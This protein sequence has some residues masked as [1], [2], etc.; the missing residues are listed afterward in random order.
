MANIFGIQTLDHIHIIEV[1]EN[2]GLNAGTPAPFGSLALDRN[3]SGVWKKGGPA[4]TDWSQILDTAGTPIPATPNSPAV[5]APLVG[6]VSIDGLIDGPFAGTVDVEVAAITGTVSIGLVDL[7]GTVTVGS[8][9]LTGTVN[10]GVDD[11]FI[12]S[13]TIDITPGTQIVNGTGTAFLSDFVVGDYLVVNGEEHEISSVNSNILMGLSTP[14][15]AGAVADA[16]YSRNFDT[17]AVVGTGT[18]F[19]TELAPGDVVEVNGEFRT[20]NSVT[21]ATNFDV[22]VDFSVHVD[23][24]TMTR[25]ES[26]T[27][28]VGTGTLFTTELSPGQTIRINEEDH[29]ISSIANDTALTLTA[30]HVNTAKNQPAQL[31]EDSTTVR[32]DGTLFNTELIVGQFLEVNGQII[33][34]ASITSDTILD[35][36]SPYSGTGAGITATKHD[37]RVIGTGTAFTGAD[38]GRAIKIAGAYYVIDSHTDGLNVTISTPT[39]VDIDTETYSLHGFIVTGIGTQFITDGLTAGDTVEIE[40]ELHEIAS[41]DGELQI[42]LVTPHDAGAAGSPISYFGAGGT[43]EGV[44]WVKTGNPTQAMFTDS[45]GEDWVLN[46]DA[47]QSYATFQGDTGSTTAS[48]A[49]DSLSIQGGDGIVTSVANDVIT[50]SSTDPFP[51]LSAVGSYT[52]DG[53]TSPGQSITGLG[54]SPTFVRVYESVSG[55]N[56]PVT[57]IETNT[58]VLLDD[59]S[60]QAIS[61]S[62]GKTVA[63][64][65]T[66]LD[67]DGFTV[68]DRGSNDHPNQAGQLYRF[69]AFG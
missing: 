10:V 47:P 2:P 64:V 8:T 28:V 21:D 1:D 3:S 15:V 31:I 49:N 66:S 65:I 37:N 27:S 22:T 59:G 4:D 67:S 18:S 30:P 46:I 52:G 23:G 34:I 13:G 55:D 41:V 12:A 57:V 7:T 51:L 50:I 68:D 44:F 42:T 32:G 33:E 40:G 19:D 29:V 56:N 60:G 61:I 9:D 39:P 20:V 11:T 54:F 25:R 69:I 63:G 38:V 35:V 14:H 53:T 17:A 36:I 45:N 43:G 5:G 16:V 24:A 62:N 58:S 48:E 6:T 26:S